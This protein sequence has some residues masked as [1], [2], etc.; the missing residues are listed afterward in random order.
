MCLQV[1]LL[2]VERQM[3]EELVD[4]FKQVERVIATRTDAVEGDQRF[5]VKVRPR[6][7][8]HH[9][10]FAGQ[11]G[12]A[13]CCLWTEAPPGCHCHLAD[14]CRHRLSAGG[15]LWTVLRPLLVHA[16]TLIPV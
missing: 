14:C 1:E 16:V 10:P 15:V 12:V 7:R 4:E 3:E 11:H 8:S 9:A 2:D 13:P 6:G 5:L